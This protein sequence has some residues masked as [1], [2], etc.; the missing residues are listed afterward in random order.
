MNTK[1]KTAIAFAMA[2]WV[3]AWFAC[4][5]QAQVL[6]LNLSE[7]L[8][9]PTATKLDFRK[10][11]IDVTNKQLDVIYRFLDAAGRDIPNPGT[12]DVDRKWSCYDRDNQ[13]LACTGAGAPYECCTGEGTGTCSTGST[14]FTDTFLFTIR[15]QDVGTRIGKGLRALI[16]NK[17]KS[18]V[19]TSGNDATLP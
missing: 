6:K 2:A 10:V 4:F 8:A 12:V 14:C 17:M 1:K 16:W 7:Q 3:I 15:S 18:A 9:V 11:T 5:G 13:N 19:L